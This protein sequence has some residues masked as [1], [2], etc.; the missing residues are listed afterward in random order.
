METTRSRALALALTAMLLTASTADALAADYNFSIH[1]SGMTI[2]GRI[3]GLALDKA[4][5]AR[6]ADPAS[7]LL[8]QVPDIVGLPA[9][10]THPYFL[11]PYWYGSNGSQTYTST[12][13]VYGF[14]VSHFQILPNQ[15]DLLLAD[16]G[17]DVFMEFN[18]GTIHTGV[19]WGVAA[20]ENAIWPAQDTTATFTL[21]NAVQVPQAQAVPEP[22]TAA[23]SATGV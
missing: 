8:Y 21:V 9:S 17:F 6:A 3:V 13:G 22:S 11:T 16:N 10:P 5:N 2:S 14:N 12:P 15:Q 1:Y 18:F 7:V 20:N 4:G 23:L 19:N